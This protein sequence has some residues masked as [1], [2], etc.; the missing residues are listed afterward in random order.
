MP[1]AIA[2]A[3]A[4]TAEL[5]AA[6]AANGKESLRADASVAAALAEAAAHGAALL[7]EVNLATVAGD[8]RSSR[9][10]LAGRAGARR[11]A[12]GRGAVSSRL[13]PAWSLAAD[14]A[15]E[16]AI[17]ANWPEQV[18]RDWAFGGGHGRRGRRL[19]PRQRRRGAP[20]RSSAGSRA[21]WP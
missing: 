7:V 10:S 8:E 16:I 20:T 14:A 9:A 4:D 13:L 12:T 1:L 15:G 11:A 2:E 5:A 3:A 18:T 6:A 21:R 17:P 19:H